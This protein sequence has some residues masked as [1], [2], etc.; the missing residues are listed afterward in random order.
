MYEHVRALTATILKLAQRICEEFEEAPGLQVTVSEGAR[1]WA[2]DLDTCAHVLTYPLQSGFLVRA[3]GARYRRA[4]RSER[5]A[6]VSN[7]FAREQPAPEMDS[8]IVRFSRVFSMRAA[9]SPLR[10]VVA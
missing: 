4:E 9:A 1:F 3:R 2:L 7:L 6:A 10:C 8:S 5:C